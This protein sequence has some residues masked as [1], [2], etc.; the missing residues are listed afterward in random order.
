MINVKDTL[1]R[2]LEIKD[3]FF[4]DDGQLMMAVKDGNPER[5]DLGFYM[6][7]YFNNGETFN[8]AISTNTVSSPDPEPVDVDDEDDEDDEE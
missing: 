7:S 2:K 3:A 8:I 5:V 1:N 6:K 4:A